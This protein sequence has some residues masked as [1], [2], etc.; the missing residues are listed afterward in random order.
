[1]A[2][3]PRIIAGLRAR[4]L[5]FVPLPA[6]VGKSRDEIMPTA[7]RSS[8]LSAQQVPGH[9]LRGA[10]AVAPLLRGVLVA[11]L[12][13]VIVRAVALLGLALVA[14][15]RRRRRHARGPLPPVTAVIPAFNESLVIERTIAAVLA[16][17]VPVDIV[18]VDDGST[19]ET[20]DLVAR[21]YRRDPRVRLLRQANAGKA[22]AL[23]AGIALCRTEIIVALDG[24]TLFAPTT[25]RRLIEPMR[26]PRIAAVAGTAEV[27]NLENT[28]ARWQAL[29]YLTQQEIERRAWDALDALPV[30]PGAVGAWR[31]RA[32]Q[33]AGGFSSDTLAE[34]ADLA[35][36]LCRRGWQVVHAPAA[37]ARTEVPT[38]VGALVRQRVR[39]SFGT[40]QALWKH[41]RAIAER[42]AFGRW[43]WPSLV[44][45]QLLLPLATP[46]ALV[47]LLLAAASGNLQPA[48][49]VGAALMGLDAVQLA[50][51]VW[52]ARRSGGEARSFPAMLTAGLLYRPLLLL[53]TL[54]SI[55][56]L[57]DGVPL[58][59]GKLSRRN[60]A[61]AYSA[62]AAAATVAARV[63]RR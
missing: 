26:D 28:L 2:A 9:V 42:H 4:G 38:T 45:F 36:A 23:R 46:L 22:A 58:G 54:R 12:A 32:L 5:Q 16:S 29:E 55:V 8:A 43:V 31:R 41:R 18:V 33:E 61:V 25:V 37:R 63:A 39:W 30:V 21:R 6:L 24:D 60:T 11:T 17:D 3:L 40:L 20:A 13:L 57:L 59:W 48:F 51:A 47:S 15:R 50:T 44:I 56:R 52:L 53:V 35:M 14:E 34:D 7:A 19:D 10:F 62:A 49:M 1:V 27:G